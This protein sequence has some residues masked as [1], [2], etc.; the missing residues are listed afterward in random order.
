MSVRMMNASF[1]GHPKN[2]I[3]I[4]VCHPCPGWFF[5]SVVCPSLFLMMSLLSVVPAAPHVVR[6]SD[7]VDV[8]VVTVSVMPSLY[9]VGFTRAAWTHRD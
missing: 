1:H 5:L 3:A 6:Q 7:C 4:T 9:P 2:N 8:V